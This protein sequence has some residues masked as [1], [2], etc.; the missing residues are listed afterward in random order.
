MVTGYDDIPVTQPGGT[1]IPAQFLHRV[2]HP[3]RSDPRAWSH[4][5]QSAGLAGERYRGSV[6]ISKIIV[7]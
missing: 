1:V 7:R 6:W 5:T 4:V 3:R 2:Q